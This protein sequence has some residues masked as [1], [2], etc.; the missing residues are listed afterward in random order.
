MVKLAKT[1]LFFTDSD[2][3]LGLAQTKTSTYANPQTLLRA[4]RGTPIDEG[5]GSAMQIYTA[6]SVLCC[7]DG[8]RDMLPLPRGGQTAKGVPPLESPF[9]A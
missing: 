6:L 2:F 3:I 4:V 9:R 8:G 7:R 5:G 1:I